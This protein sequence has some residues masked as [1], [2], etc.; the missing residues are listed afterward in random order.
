MLNRKIYKELITQINMKK[1]MNKTKKE[2]VEMIENNTK[3]SK[4]QEKATTCDIFIRLIQN[5]IESITHLKPNNFTFTREFIGQF[6][7]KETLE[8][9]SIENRLFLDS[10]IDKRCKKPKSI[11]KSLSRK[12]GLN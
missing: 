1:L 3:I 6:R 5:G 12:Y 11:I 10:E 8:W 7:M 9:E 2:L 4:P